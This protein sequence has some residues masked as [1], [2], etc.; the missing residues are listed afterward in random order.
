VTIPNASKT[1]TIVKNGKSNRAKRSFCFLTR[2]FTF[3]RICL[4]VIAAAL[5]FTDNAEG[6]AL[7][8][9]ALL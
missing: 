9:L 5:E 2:S 3:L 8:A 7:R 1:I 4:G 6:R